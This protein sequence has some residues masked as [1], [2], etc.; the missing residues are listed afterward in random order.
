MPRK[1]QLPSALEIK[2]AR[3]GY[4]AC[5]TGKEF[6]QRV[7]EIQHIWEKRKVNKPET[8]DFEDIIVHVPKLLG[9][10]LIDEKVEQFKRTHSVDVDEKQKKKEWK[11]FET[12]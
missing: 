3:C 5:W 2:H 10:K 4:T 11:S 8:V 9:D 12:K 1:L 7:Q 6:F